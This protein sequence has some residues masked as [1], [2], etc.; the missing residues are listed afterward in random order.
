MEVCA[1]E[2]NLG[3]RLLTPFIYHLLE[4]KLARLEPTE[5]LDTW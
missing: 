5:P 2:R 3:K 4:Q 1:G